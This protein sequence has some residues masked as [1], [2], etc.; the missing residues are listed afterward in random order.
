MKKKNNYDSARELINRRNQ[1]RD[2]DWDKRTS[3]F[4]RA[5]V[6][7]DIWKSYNELLSNWDFVMAEAYYQNLKGQVRAIN[8]TL[9]ENPPNISGIIPLLN[10]VIDGNSKSWI[11][12]VTPLYESLA[13]DFAYLQVELLLPDEFKENYVYTEAEQEQILR[14]RRRLPRQTIIAEGFHPRRKRGQAIPLNRNSYNRA[15]KGF[16][17]QRLNT[18]VP[19][20]SNTMKKNLNTAL[21]KSIDQAIILGLTGC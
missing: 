14:S 6:K 20:M 8:K 4:E 3:R 5:E 2:L 12:N 17:E 13:I 9:A 19:D 16:I 7:D 10:S 15:A 21:R 1:L 18:Y 11:E